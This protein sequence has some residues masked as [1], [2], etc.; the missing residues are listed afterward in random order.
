MASITYPSSLPKPLPVSGK[1]QSGVIRT[2]MDVGPDKVRRRSTAI[3]NPMA[4]TIQVS[5]TQF[6]TFRN[7]FHTTSLEGSIEFNMA[8]PWDDST[9]EFRFTQTY[10]WVIVT[11]GSNPDER[12]FQI[13]IYMEKLP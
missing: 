10:D 13:T 6:T 1:P 2:Q 11:G 5:G 7:F 8:D 9:Q 4:F 12:V 3:V